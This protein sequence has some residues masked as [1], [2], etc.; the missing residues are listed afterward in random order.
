LNLFNKVGTCECSGIG[1]VPVEVTAIAGRQ[2]VSRCIDLAHTRTAEV[3]ADRT[4]RNE[5]KVDHITR[6]QREAAHF[7]VGQN[8][9]DRCRSSLKRR[10]RIGKDLNLSGDSADLK[11]EI[12]ADLLALTQLDILARRR[13]ET[14]QCRF[15]AIR[16]GLKTWNL[17]SAGFIR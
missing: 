10:C 12:E 1:T 9:A 8:A 11:R 13:L 2:T 16:S 4:C 14:G 15:Q 17:V 6:C 3:V 7:S 5:S